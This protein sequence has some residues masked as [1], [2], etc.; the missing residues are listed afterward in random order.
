MEAIVNLQVDLKARIIRAQTN[1]KKS[2][3]E[4]LTKEY[5]EGRL[6][7]LEALWLEFTSGHNK[8][9]C[10]YNTKELKSIDYKKD[11]IYDTTE[12]VFI[13]YKSD[14]KEKLSH[15]NAPSVLSKS[16]CSS[17]LNVKLPKIDLPKF[18]GHY[19]EWSSFQDLFSSLIISNSSLSNVQKLHYLKSSLTGEAEQLLRHITIQD[20]NFERCW[21]LLTERYNNKRYISHQVIK[22]FLSQRNLT[23]ESAQGLKDLLD[24]TN[25]CLASLN[26]VG[27]DTKNW[28]IL[29]IH[30]LSLKL[31]TETRRQWEFHVAS[32]TDDLPTYKNFEEFLTTRFRANEFLTAKET[33]RVSQVRNNTKTLHVANITCPFCTEAHKL[34]FCKRFHKES[35]ESRRKFVLENNVCFVCMGYNHSARDCRTK[36][37][38]KICKRDHHS[39]LHPNGRAVGTTSNNAIEESVVAPSD[40]ATFSS[41]GPTPVVSC[42]STDKVRQ[43]VLLATALV[44]AISR[45]GEGYDVRALL[46]QG[47]QSSFV[48]ESTVQYLGLEKVMTRNNITGLGGEKN[49]VSKAVVNIEIRSRFDPSV[50]IQV[51]A[52]VLKSITSLLPTRRVEAIQW[53][54]INRLVLADPKYYAPSR[55]DLL[56]GAEVYGKII[57]E[58]LV[59]GPIGTPIAQATS[60][61]WILS[62]VVNSLNKPPVS[63]NVMHCCTDSDVYLKKF[64]EIESDVPQPK[65]M[66]FTDEEKRCEQYFAETTKRDINGRYIVRLPYKNGIPA[67]TASK[68]IAEKRFKSLEKRLDKDESLKYKYQQCLDEYLNLDH[69][70]I[71]PTSEIENPKSIYLPHHAVVK[72]DRETTKVRIVFDASCKGGNNVSLNDQLL[73]GPTLQPELRHIIMQWRSS[74]ICISADIVKMY[75]QVKIDQQD[76]DSQR[77]LWREHKDKKMK[78]YRHTRVT[79]GTAS[80]PYLAVKALQQ[81]AHDHGAD[82]PSASERVLKHFYVDDLLT[83]VQTIE[84][85]ITVYKELTELLS[86]AG[87]ELQKWNSNSNELRKAMKAW[88]GNEDLKENLKIREDELT[89]IMGLTWNHTDD[90]FRYVVNLPTLQEPITKRKIISDISRLY[91]PLGWIG[92]S[93][94][95]AK[96]I[97]Q[98]LWLAALDWDD[99]VPDN[100]LKEWVTYREE[101]PMLEKIRIPRWVGTTATDVHYEL[102]GF[103]D[104]SKTAYAAVVYMRVV[105][106][107]EQVTVSLVTARTKVAPVKQVSIPRL[108]LCGAVLLSKLL[109]EVSQVMNVQKHDIHAWTD[110]TIVLAWLNSHPTTEF[111][112]GSAAE[113]RLIQNIAEALANNYCEWHFIPPHSPNFGGLWEAGVKS[114]KHHLKK[115]IG[116]STLTFEEMATVLAQIEACLNS[117]PMSVLSNEPDFILT[118]GHFLIGEAPLTV[119]DFD[120]E[121]VK[122]NNLRR[123]QHT[124]RMLQSFWRRWSQEYLNK[125]LHRYKWTNKNSEPSI[126]DVVIIKEDNLPPCRW[127]YGRIID[128]HPGDDNIVRVVTLKTK[129]G[130]L[131]RPVSKLC[132]LPL[133]R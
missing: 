83:G 10:M 72:E 90:T 61:G 30:I 57:Q 16:H 98:K 101:Q 82:Y 106:S 125:F 46:D 59:K 41:A 121:H 22:R 26:N 37:K 21:E 131:K 29:V 75:R 132:F 15:F 68:E 67:V 8:L 80:A 116:N 96:T 49:I 87:F 58:G 42:F 25:D 89:K 111:K 100:L 129:S 19:S 51:R 17:I 88:D 81:V 44:Q 105:D 13:E 1:F 20:C 48:T 102:H 93:M 77:I 18:S 33:T 47:S 133:E 54:G 24:T 56:L 103:C 94:I 2:P 120:I 84:E 36:I 108:E 107:L 11:D 65:R 60:L 6:E 104:A 3:K 73:V 40:G 55:I 110:S 12:D 70:E 43:Q 119:P 74:P 63:I 69:M 31:D 97:I 109:L 39:L 34:I 52:H 128:T 118:P 123:W 71:V 79:F 86:K 91:D 7:A 35:V 32:L 114:V 62:G 130:T 117:R 5:L 50:A 124:Q 9:I 78:H 28:D 85:G 99:V 92:P 127:L 126:G 14:I 4:R 64:W 45:N 53:P 38:C 66:M 95:V 115:V 23:V 112:K 27:I 113:R 122:V 76:A